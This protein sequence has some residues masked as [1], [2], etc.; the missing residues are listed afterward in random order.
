MVAHLD[1][2]Y[3]C[4]CERW[5]ELW[6]LVRELEQ[7][8]LYSLARADS[9]GINTYEK[10]LSFF[11]PFYYWP[12]SLSPFLSIMT[13]LY[14]PGASV[15]TIDLYRKKEKKK[16]RKKNTHHYQGLLKISFLLWNYS[17]MYNKDFHMPFYSLSN[18]GVL[19]WSALYGE[20]WWGL[21]G[22]TEGYLKQSQR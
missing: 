13:M 18:S 15:M 17:F 2:S 10:Q 4:W 7:W 5:W 21:G 8:N 12:F 9:Q 1:G 11:Y 22:N 6:L 19:D 14:F 20:Q 16:T 3:F